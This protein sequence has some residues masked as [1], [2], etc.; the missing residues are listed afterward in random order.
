[1]TD[2][3]SEIKRNNRRALPKFLIML[4]LS[5]A[6]GFAL[7]YFWFEYGLERIAQGLRA[8]VTFFGLHMAPWLLVAMALALPFA[9]A[10][11]YRDANR[12]LI[13]WDGED[14]AVSDAAEKR[15]SWVVWFT[16]TALILSFCFITAVYAQDIAAFQDFAYAAALAGFMVILIESVVLQQKCVDL[17]KKIQPEKTASVYDTKF[18]KKWLESC[19]EAEK[20]MIGKCAYKAYRAGNNACAA[21]AI[22]LALSALLLDTGFL[23]ALVVCAIWITNQTAYYREAMRLSKAGNRIS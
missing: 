13:D 2:Q 9:G 14:E 17:G 6:G 1:M 8:A 10:K 18:H 5:L 4:A 12:R 20:I 19:D 16:D 7:G 22:I 3:C 11:L 21:A 23:P 15:L